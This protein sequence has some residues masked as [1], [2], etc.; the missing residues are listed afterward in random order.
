MGNEH[1]PEVLNHSSVYNTRFPPY[2]HFV[3]SLP[4]VAYASSSPI[5]RARSCHV[6]E[7]EPFEQLHISAAKRPAVSD[8]GQTRIVRLIY[9]LPNDRSFNPD[10]VDSMKARIPRIQTFFSQQMQ[11]RGH[12]NKTFPV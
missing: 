2:W 9:F 4:A 12:G 5:D 7:S 11:A 6:V 10:V 1:D 3:L 8:S